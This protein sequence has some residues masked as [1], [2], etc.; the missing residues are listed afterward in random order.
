MYSLPKLNQEKTKYMNRLITSNAIVSV[1]KQL[2]KNNNPGPDCFTGKSYQTFREELTSIYS[3]YPPKLM[4]E[5]FPIHS[6]RLALAWYQNL[7]KLDKYLSHT[8]THTHIHTHKYWSISL[9][10]IDAKIL[11]KILANQI[12]VEFSPGMQDCFNIH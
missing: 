6:T 7:Q 9:M 4:K 1:V 10:N 5:H 8:H 3:K 2:L 11:N 12:Q